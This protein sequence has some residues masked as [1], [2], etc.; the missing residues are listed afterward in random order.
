MT[1]LL[2]RLYDL[3]QTKAAPEGVVVRRS[4]PPERDIVLH[5]VKEIFSA[6]WASECA[7]AFSSHPITTWI[8]VRN[9]TMVGFA[10]HDATQKGFF[11]PM[12]VIPAERGKGIGVAL[13]MATL[14]GMREAGYA[15]AVIGGVGPAEW[16]ARHCGAIEIPGSTPGIYRGMLSQS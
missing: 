6:G 5:W 13:L 10:C 12:G 9:R 11:G 14:T 8:A 7:V 4:L 2:V 15:Y 3:P 1:D 16:Y